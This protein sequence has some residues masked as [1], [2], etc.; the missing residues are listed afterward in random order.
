MWLML[1][2]AF[3][4]IVSKDC[5]E[6]SL[7]VRA[8]RPGDI[9]KV[10]GRR[11]RVTRATDADYL[12]RAVVA[13]EE[14]IS[15]MAREVLRVDYGNFKDSVADEQLHDAYMRVWSTM[16]SLQDPRPYSE[17][18]TNPKW[19][20]QRPLTVD[21]INKVL[22][23]PGLPK[24]SGEP[25]KRKKNSKQRRKARKLIRKNGASVGTEPREGQ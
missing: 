25:R 6:G 16:A 9:E 10:F 7:L 23:L 12:F 13:R 1:N 14:I 20:A 18:F 24:S 3:L 11:T 22:G 2:D 21:V 17:P 5:P 8:R 19:K 15:A 4:S